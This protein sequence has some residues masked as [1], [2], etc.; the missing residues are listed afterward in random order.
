MAHSE[1]RR[2]HRIAYFT[3]ARLQIEGKQILGVI[4]DLSLQGALLEVDQQQGVQTQQLAELHFSLGE[5]LFE[6]EM[7]VE[8]VHL[9]P[10]RIGLKCL[11]IDMESISHLRRLVE[12]NLGDEQLLERDLYAMLAS[13]NP[14]P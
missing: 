7:S 6:V 10:G 8:V 2:F 11:N 4:H 3:P 12:L 9:E 1:Q 5:S 13:Q 14:E